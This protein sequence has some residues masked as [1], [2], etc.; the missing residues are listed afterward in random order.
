[1]QQDDEYDEDVVA[2]LKSKARNGR[3]T[4]WV[5][6][7]GVRDAEGHVK[8]LWTLDTG[9]QTFGD[10]LKFVF[11]KNVA[12]ARRDNKRTTGANDVAVI[13]R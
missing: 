13:K 5:T 6:E 10:D 2:S 3:A 12:M 4:A 7:K 9:G 11:G 8:V 1:M